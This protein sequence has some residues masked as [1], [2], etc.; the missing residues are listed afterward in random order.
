MAAP[1][2]EIVPLK[3]DPKYDDYDFP[4]VSATNQSGHAGH[5]TPEQEAQVHQLRMSLEQKGFTERLDTLTLLRFLRARKFDVALAEVMFVNSEGWRKEINLDDLVQNF[6]YTEKAQIFEYY[7]QYYHK[8]DKDGRPVYIE[9]LGKCDLTAM[10][11]I[12]TQ[13]RML[14]NLAVEY[15]KVSDPRLP[16]CSRKSGHLLETCCTIMDLK[17]VGLSKISSVYGYVKEASAMSQNHYPERLGRL[18]LINAPWGFSS[19]FSMIKSFLDPVTVEKIH[20]L[21]GG[22][23]S[24]LLA[25]VPAE[26]LPKQFGG[27]CDC[28]GGC[29]FSD[30][31]PWSEPEFYRPPK[32][33]KKSGEEKKE[34]AAVIDTTEGKGETVPAAAVAPIPEAGGVAEVQAK[35]FTDHGIAPA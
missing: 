29:G 35:E 28:E 30:A 3:T 20:V 32:W 14:Q 7:P 10:N 18:Y 1:P 26:N 33:A 2:A 15:E 11:R 12:T 22:Y 23:Q 31:G 17:G 24:Q 27:T 13:E 16:A 4:T 19:V 5:L 6:E 25:Q 8:T 34:D 21:G 9:Q